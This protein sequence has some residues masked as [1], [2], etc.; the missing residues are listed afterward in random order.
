[1]ENNLPIN[2]LSLVMQIHDDDTV[3][4]IAA[5]NISDSMD[6]D[7][8]HYYVNLLHGLQEVLPMMSDHFSEVGAKTR[9]IN[10]IMGDDDEADIAFE[11][12]QELLEAIAAK[13]VVSFKKKMH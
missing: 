12:D 5:C 13:K 11:P 4:V 10:M 3:N 9:I 7:N 2:T 8:A 6:E 1:M